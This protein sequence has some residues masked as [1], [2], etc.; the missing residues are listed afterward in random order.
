VLIL[1]DLRN[2][3]VLIFQTNNILLILGLITKNIIDITKLQKLLLSSLHKIS[4][5]GNTSYIDDI[6]SS[7]NTWV[8]ARYKPRESA[9][10]AVA[11]WRPAVQYQLVHQNIAN[12]FCNPILFAIR[13]ST[14]SKL[15][16]NMYTVACRRVLTNTLL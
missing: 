4:E 5:K 16:K 8:A 3:T 1:L 12:F 7:G 14:F 11:L 6:Q 15:C 9:A 2:Q 13:N 10:V